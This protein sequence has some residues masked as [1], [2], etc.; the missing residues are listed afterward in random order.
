[1]KVTMLKEGLEPR[2][3]SE[4]LITVLVR[5]PDNQIEELLNCIK[6]Y[7]MRGHSFPVVVD[8]HDSERIKEFYIDGDGSAAI[9]KTETI[10]G[11]DVLDEI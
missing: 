3:S 8:Q 6:D 2:D 5:D 1:M 7:S 11:D 9:I 4:K 10:Q